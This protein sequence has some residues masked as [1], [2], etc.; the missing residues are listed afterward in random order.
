MKMLK[1]SRGQKENTQAR[2]DLK[3]ERAPQAWISD[4]IEGV[5]AT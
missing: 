1:S 5:H 2:A 3:G 4:I